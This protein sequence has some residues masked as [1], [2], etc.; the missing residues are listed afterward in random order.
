MNNQT[1]ALRKAHDLFTQHR[2]EQQNYEGQNVIWNWDTR[3]IAF[4]PYK[5]SKSY[6]IISYSF[7]LKDLLK[8]A[9]VC[10]QSNS[11]ISK[12]LGQIASM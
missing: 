7:I 11:G 3:P 4:R 10:W 9:G 12:E 5:S 1:Y 6:Y 2:V 8:Y